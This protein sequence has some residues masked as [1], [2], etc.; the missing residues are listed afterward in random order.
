MRL[1]TTHRLLPAALL[2]TSCSGAAPSSDTGSAEASAAISATDETAGSA[3]A[4]A[5]MET[6][7]MGA[8]N[9]T[10]LSSESDAV[11]D[12]TDTSATG[13]TSA[14][15]E[16]ADALPDQQNLPA[17]YTMESFD[18]VPAEFQEWH[19][20]IDYGTVETDVEYYS[21]TA[22]ICFTVLAGDTI[23]TCTKDP[24]CRLCMERCCTTDLR[25]L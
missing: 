17:P 23:P 14:G 3:T 4:E 24:S 9:I 7:T 13:T 12:L 21:N 6:S 2:I 1:R 15:T 25:S 11:S 20:D 8:T 10:A 19:D 18:T 16:S 22:S 5:D